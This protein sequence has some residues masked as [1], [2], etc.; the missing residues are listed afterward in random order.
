[1]ISCYKFHGRDDLLEQVAV[2]ENK[3][4]MVKTINPDNTISII[5]LDSSNPLFTLPDGTQA[6]V[7]L[8]ESGAA[9]VGTIETGQQNSL[10]QAGAEAVLMPAATVNTMCEYDMVRENNIREKKEFFKFVFK[11]DLERTD[12]PVAKKVPRKKVFLP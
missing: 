11:E 7:L 12:K 1:M 8:A 10:Q 2:G 4:A 6:Q 9:E 5:H 3:Q